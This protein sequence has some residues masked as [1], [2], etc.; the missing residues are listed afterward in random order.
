MLG[1]SGL[2]IAE[3]VFLPPILSAAR[4]RWCV[5]P[6]HQMSTPCVC[7]AINT[8]GTALKITCLMVVA[9]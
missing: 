9:D 3:L 8:A 4:V 7:F 1:S 6:Q 2:G 5:F